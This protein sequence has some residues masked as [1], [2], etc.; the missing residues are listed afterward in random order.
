MLQPRDVREHIRRLCAEPLQ[1]T[2][3]LPVNELPLVVRARIQASEAGQAIVAA[4]HAELAP[5][6]LI[7]HLFVR[8]V[9]ALCKAH[10]ILQPEHFDRSLVNHL[11]RYFLEDDQ[12]RF[13]EDVKKQVEMQPNVSNPVVVR[14]F[15]MVQ[16]LVR[17]LTCMELLTCRSAHLQLG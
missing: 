15:C 4:R 14:L 1:Q 10:P 2:P 3:P 11:H 13:L 9:Q 17:R 16:V 7:D 12:L 5:S 8:T 6:I